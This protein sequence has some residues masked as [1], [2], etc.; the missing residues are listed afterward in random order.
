M[1]GIGGDLIT[2]TFPNGRAFE[3]LVV[4]IPT[5]PHP[6]PQGGMVGHAI[7]RCIASPMIIKLLVKLV[8]GWERL[9]EHL[10]VC[11]L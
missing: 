10:D 4:Q 2:V 3:F 7:D 8:Q 6:L 5:P 11:H 1:Q 9:Q